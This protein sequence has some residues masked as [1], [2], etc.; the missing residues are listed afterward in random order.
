[1]AD[2]YVQLGSRIDVPFKYLLAFSIPQVTRSA[3]LIAIAGQ[4]ATGDTKHV[5]RIA[6]CLSQ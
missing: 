2:A 1:M 5:K 3:W 4:K 6:S